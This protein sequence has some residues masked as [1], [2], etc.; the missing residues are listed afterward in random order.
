MFKKLFN[1][2]YFE[3]Y[4]PHVR[5]TLYAVLYMGVGYVSIFNYEWITFGVWLFALGVVLFVVISFGIAWRGPI[6][7]WEQIENTI[8]VM[9]KINSP[10]IW[11][12]LGFKEVPN[13][14]V[15]VE[16]RVDEH[17]VYQGETKRVLQQNVIMLN[18][19]AN[20]MLLSGKNEF[21]E[22]KFKSVIPNFRKTKKEFI[23]KGYITQST[24]HPKSPYVMTRKGMTDIIYQ[25]AD[26]AIKLQIEKER[27]NGRT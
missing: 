4:V 26:N 16:K 25:Y 21:T 24:K 12:A 1:Q 15:I 14:T 18:T 2:F 27:E 23:A 20:K 13:Q 19:I 9:L 11:F 7:Y 5:H 6:Q 22:D 8:K 10:E 3:E 17:G